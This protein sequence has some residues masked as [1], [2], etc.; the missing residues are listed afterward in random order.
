[1]GSLILCTTSLS[2]FWLVGE[3]GR[4][5]QALYNYLALIYFSVLISLLCQDVTG[6]TPSWQLSRYA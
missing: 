5:I 3:L 6:L 1:M 4:F 2:Q